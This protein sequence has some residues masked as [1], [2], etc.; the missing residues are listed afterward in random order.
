MQNP[1]EILLYCNWTKD[2]GLKIHCHSAHYLFNY[3]LGRLCTKKTK[4]NNSTFKQKDASTKLKRSLVFSFSE[5]N[6]MLKNGNSFTRQSIMP[7]WF[8][9]LWVHANKLKQVNFLL[10]VYIYVK[11]CSSNKW[12]ISVLD[13]RKRILQYF[14]QATNN[15]LRRQCQTSRSVYHAV[16]SQTHNAFLSIDN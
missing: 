15:D 5:R 11:Q 8:H 14:N 6:G 13:K 16:G 3:S 10:K 9:F 4:I 2:R 1:P 7:I 12:H